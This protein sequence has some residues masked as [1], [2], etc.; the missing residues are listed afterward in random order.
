MRQSPTHKEPGVTRRFTVTFVVTVGYLL[1]E[2][3][4]LVTKCGEIVLKDLQPGVLQ[5]DLGHSI[6]TCPSSP[7]HKTIYCSLTL[8]LDNEY[9]AGKKKGMIV[10]ESLQLE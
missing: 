9:E 6:L 4:F 1:T 10:C 3:K 5:R 8:A 2:F 7:S